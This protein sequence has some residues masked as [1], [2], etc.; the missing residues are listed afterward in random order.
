M[1][2]D[3]EIK[4]GP[5]GLKALDF[6]APQPLY[7]REN[8]SDVS[9][10]QAC[11]IDRTEYSFPLKAEPKVILD[12]GA[13]IGVVTVLMAIIYPKAKIFC[14]EPIVENYDILQLNIEKYKNVKACNFALGEPG[15]RE[16]FDSDDP[17]NLGGFSL[18]NQG[19][20]L[21]KSKKILVQDPNHALDFFKIQPDMIKIDCEGAEY[22]ILSRIDRD[23]LEG[24]RWIFGELH[25]QN[26]FKLL[27][28]LSDRFEISVLKQMEQ[29]V[30]PFYARSRS[31]KA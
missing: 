21:K 2:Q 22:E 6:G 24:V 15:E 12:I 13:N 17:A 11:L 20:D 26:D 30:F 25:G 1:K 5:S 4:D 19:V 9:I 10:I 18:F 14:F 8:T 29:R 3:A 23:K 16:I 31:L 28:F 7:F 27:D